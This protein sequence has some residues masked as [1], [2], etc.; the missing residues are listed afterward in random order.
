MKK[1]LIKVSLE[2]VNGIPRVVIKRGTWASILVD[3]KEATQLADNIIDLVE[4]VQK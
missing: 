4:K 3:V 2:T 1:P